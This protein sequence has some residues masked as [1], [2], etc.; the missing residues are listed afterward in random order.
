[1]PPCP[2]PH[3]FTAS[4]TRGWEEQI[5]KGQEVSVQPCAP[6][7]DLLGVIQEAPQL[8]QSLQ[9]TPAEDSSHAYS[10]L[11]WHLTEMPDSKHF[12]QAV[13]WQGLHFAFVKGM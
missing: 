1:M 11:N 10:E 8:S 4:E 12:K 7:E 2:A 3:T 9:H 6:P 13:V 5:I